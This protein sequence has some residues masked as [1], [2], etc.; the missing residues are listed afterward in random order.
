MDV[1]VA[2][3]VNNPPVGTGRFNTV[4]VVGTTPGES[5]TD[6]A[7]CTGGTGGP[8]PSTSTSEDDSTGRVLADVF[9]LSV[10]NP[11][12]GTTDGDFCSS[13]SSGSS[14]PASWLTSAELAVGDKDTTA[15]DARDGSGPGS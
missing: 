5:F 2:G 6:P 3:V 8:S 12:S 14:V 1:D 9:S 10:T 15:D 13:P 11:E 4:V 7:D